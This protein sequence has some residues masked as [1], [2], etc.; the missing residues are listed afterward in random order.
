MIRR[1]LL[2]SVFLSLPATSA[3]AADTVNDSFCVGYIRTALGE[4]PVEG[5]N[6][7]NL[8]LA[9][10]ETVKSTINANQLSEQDFQSGRDRFKQQLASNNV[11][12]MTDTSDDD[13]DLGR[14]STWV[15]W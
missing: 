14:N 2:L 15:W 13:C 4:F 10:H 12:A 9:W 8:W 5:L 1:I 11:Q 7:N 6:R 3:W